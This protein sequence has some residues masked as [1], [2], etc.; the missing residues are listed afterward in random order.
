MK[1]DAEP[2]LRDIIESIQKIE[3]YMKDVSKNRFFE[4][5]QL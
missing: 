4:T 2:F 3:E 5:T 1:K